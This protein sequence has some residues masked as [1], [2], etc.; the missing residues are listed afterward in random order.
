MFISAAQHLPQ[1]VFSRFSFIIKF[2]FYLQ[3]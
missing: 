3:G 2:L 1:V